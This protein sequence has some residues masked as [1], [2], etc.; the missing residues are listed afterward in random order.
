MTRRT[1]VAATL[2]LTLLAFTTVPASDLKVMSFNI[3]YGTAEDGDHAWPHRASHVIDI[4]ASFAPDLLGT[5]ECLDFQRDALIAALPGHDVVAA[6][7]DDGA[8]AGEM[9]ACFYRRD[10]FELIES[11]TFWL[12]EIPETIGSRGWD[13]ALPRI[14]TWLRLRDRESSVELL[15]LDTHFDHQG[16]RARRESAA[17]LNQWLGAHRQA[18]ALIVTGDFNLPADA[19][20]GSAQQ[21]LLTGA[22]AADEPL[23]L[24][25]WTVVHGEMEPKEG[26]F[27]G[28]GRH[29]RP[30]RIDWILVSDDLQVKK[31]GI[32]RRRYGDIW[33][34]DHFPVT[35]VIGLPAGR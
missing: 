7:R 26:T 4:I 17:L 15:W 21:L 22:E 29:P 2:L 32:D 3:R 11:G 25:T 18:A 1:L 31:A 23:L 9:C 10:R 35:A 14:A 33:P 12:S 5:Q 28:F 20:P 30:G 27:S 8:G 13:A 6:G 16:E 34:S 24:D 19:K